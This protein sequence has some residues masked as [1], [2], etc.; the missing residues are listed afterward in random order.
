MVE[1]FGDVNR[2]R[3]KDSP[4]AER[5]LLAVKYVCVRCGKGATAS[6]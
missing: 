3:N 2:A 6:S 4:K 5:G 1:G